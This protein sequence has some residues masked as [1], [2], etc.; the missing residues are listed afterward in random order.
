[1]RI[2]AKLPNSGELPE[3]IGIPAMAEALEG[4]GFD[5]LWVSDHI[6]QPSVIRSPYPFAADGKATWPTTMPWVDAVV[7]LALAAAVTKRAALGTAVLVLPLRNPVELAKQAASIDRASGGRLTLGVG[8]GWLREEFEALGADFDRRGPRLTEWI[9]IA[10]DC[11]TGRTTGRTSPDYELPPDVICEPTPAQEGGIPVLI[12]G[13]SR[14]ALRRAGALGDG[15]LA[16]ASATG[17]LHEGVAG[18]VASVRAAA[19]ESERNPQ[20]PRIVLRIVESAG[21]SD[22]VA[23]ALPELERAGVDEVIVDV[24]WEAGEPAAELERLR[25]A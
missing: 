9:E 23:R 25:N 15:W 22:T 11:W 14:A 21:R 7:A 2:S 4:A 1:M 19:D 17:D 5:G 12:G 20:G 3:R 6:V 10:R 24:D 18:G 16:H 13:H 8:A